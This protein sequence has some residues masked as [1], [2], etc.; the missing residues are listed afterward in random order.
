MLLRVLAALLAL[1]SCGP[2][3]PARPHL[4]CTQHQLGDAGAA[5]ALQLV[6]LDNSAELVALNDGDPV[7]LAPPS[8]GG[9]VIYAG[10]RAT[11]LMACGATTAAELVDASGLAL[12][13]LDQRTT[14]FVDPAGAF[15]GA[16]PDDLTYELPNI[17]ACPDHLGRGVAGQPAFLRVTVTD[18]NGKTATAQVKVVPTCAGGDNGFCACACGPNYTPGKC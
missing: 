7:R 9:F 2:D 8:Q 6:T 15:F 18:V 1:G 13:N 3:I 11:N 14:S 16:S 4:A 5:I 17:P 12:T 10:A